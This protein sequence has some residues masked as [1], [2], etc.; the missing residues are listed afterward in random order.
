MGQKCRC[1][2]LSPRRH[3]SS[4]LQLLLN[5]L[6]QQPERLLINFNELEETKDFCIS[7]FRFL[8]P[9]IPLKLSFGEIEMFKMNFGIQLPEKTLRC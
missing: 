7:T 2:Q 5:G 9:T 4:F 6:N 8:P 3:C 1:L